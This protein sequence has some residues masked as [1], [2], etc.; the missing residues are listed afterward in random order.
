MTSGRGQVGNMP[1]GIDP[2]PYPQKIS[3]E[4]CRIGLASGNLVRACSCLCALCDWL[5]SLEP[6]M[7]DTS[8]LQEVRSSASRSLLYRFFREH[9][10]RFGSGAWHLYRTK[11]L[12]LMVPHIR[13][14][15]R[16][17]PASRNGTACF[18]AKKREK[19][20]ASVSY[21]SAH[22]ALFIKGYAHENQFELTSDGLTVA[23]LRVHRQTW[24]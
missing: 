5:F 16:L 6:A 17:P 12:P 13:L 3:C 24:T 4:N 11:E 22:T 7:N 18:A 1:Q 21:L 14:M 20:P 15:T 23:S 9:R 8:G 10:H 2:S 19:V